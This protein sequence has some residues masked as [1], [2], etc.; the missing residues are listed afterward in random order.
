MYK[1]N[2]TKRFN[3]SLFIIPI[4]ATI[5]ICGA[6][7]ALEKKGI[8]NFYTASPNSSE[9][10]QNSP[11]D[12]ST[13]NPT[14][15]IDYGPAKVED[16]TVVSDKVPGTQPI[17]VVNADLSVTITSVRMNTAGTAFLIKAAVEGTESGS[18]KVEMN[19]GSSALTS[20]GGVELVSGLYSCMNLEIPLS[21]LSEKGTWGVIVTVTDKAGASASTNTEVIL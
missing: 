1:N 11:L 14:N 5:M 3:Y 18:C 19:K 9:S 17:P 16:T 20:S 4:L 10:S 8:T 6:L 21:E 13:I 2:Q 7:F 15:T 12:G